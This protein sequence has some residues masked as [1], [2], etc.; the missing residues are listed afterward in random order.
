MDTIGRNR[1]DKAR[2]PD[3]Q[4]EYPLMTL[5]VFLM[6]GTSCVLVAGCGPNGLPSKVVHGTVTAGGVKVD[7]GRVRI[8]PI[9]GTPGPASMAMIINGQYRID[10]RGGVPVG[11][12][13]VE[14]DARRRKVQSTN[15]GDIPWRDDTLPMGPAVYATKDSPLVVEVTADSNG[16]FDFELLATPK[17]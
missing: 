5:V 9:D 1:W 11:K 8:V 12:H 16:Q 6:A 17:R 7:A 3:R 14:I 15:Q 13:R 4:A 10:V 2:R